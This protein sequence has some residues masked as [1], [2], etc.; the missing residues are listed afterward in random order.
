MTRE[1]KSKNISA[2]ID[3]DLGVDVQTEGSQAAIEYI[4]IVILFL[5]V[6]ISITVLVAQYP[7]RNTSPFHKVY[8]TTCYHGRILRLREAA[9]STTVYVGNPLCIAM[10]YWGW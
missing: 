2:D 8:Q 1:S 10:D 6:P 5:D 9:E 3:S 4:F 7:K